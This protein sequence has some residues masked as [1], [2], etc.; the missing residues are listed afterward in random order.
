V[1]LKGHPNVR[2]DV[3]RVPGSFEIPLMIQRLAKKKKYDVFLALGAIIKGQTK[4]FDLVANECARGCMD[5]MLKTNVPVVF[6]VL[7]CSSEAQARARSR[8]K[9]NRGKLGA[10][11]ALWWLSGTIGH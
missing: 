9:W 6:E 8:G 11:V 10:E 4:H 1:V 7:A 3:Y 2:F 5:V